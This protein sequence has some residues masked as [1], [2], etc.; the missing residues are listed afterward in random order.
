MPPIG[1]TE[2]YHGYLTRCAVRKA[3]STFFFLV[4]DVHCIIQSLGLIIQ[5]LGLG[6]PS[7]RGRN[8]KAIIDCP[9][10]SCAVGR[11]RPGDLELR[12]QEWPTR[13]VRSLHHMAS[14]GTAEFR[15]LANNR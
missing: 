5:S 3:R 8:A 9:H 6:V 15:R 13:V 1:L 11:Q 4:A 14:Q 2:T 12:L 7:S 10:H